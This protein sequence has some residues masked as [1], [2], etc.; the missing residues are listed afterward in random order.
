M[1]NVAP[2]RNLRRGK[3]AVQERNIGHYLRIEY[4][5]N[6][7]SELRVGRWSPAGARTESPRIRD[8]REGTF[9]QKTPG[10]ESRASGRNRAVI[11]LGP[12]STALDPASVSR[13][14]GALDDQ[15]SIVRVV[16]EYRKPNLDAASPPRF[17]PDG[18]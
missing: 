14:A 13:S 10:A 9:R 11:S 16:G 7:V 3:P 12:V 2:D 17:A 18:D 8:D 1:A 15:Q 5:V 4:P 6:A